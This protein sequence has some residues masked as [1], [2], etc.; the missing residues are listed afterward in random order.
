MDTAPPPSSAPFSPNYPVLVEDLSGG[1][2][3]F[4]VIQGNTLKG[5]ATSATPHAIRVHGIL[6][7]ETKGCSIAGNTI[8]FCDRSVI[9]TANTSFCSVVANCGILITN[10]STAY[11]NSGASNEVAN[12]TATTAF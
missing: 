12:N 2:A 10:A 11:Q 3:K 7:G 4:T 9:L 8:S 5:V 1:G 6:P